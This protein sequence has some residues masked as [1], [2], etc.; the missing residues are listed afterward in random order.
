MLRNRWPNLCLPNC[1]MTHAYGILHWLSNNT[2]NNTL[3]IL[4]VK[5]KRIIGANSEN[6]S[7]IV[8]KKRRIH[9]D[10]GLG[11]TVPITALEQEPDGCTSGDG[12]PCEEGCDETEEEEE[13]AVGLSEE[14]IRRAAAL[15]ILER[16]PTAA[17]SNGWDCNWCQLPLPP[18]TIGNQT[19]GWMYLE[20]GWIER[21]GCPV[22]CEPSFGRKSIYK[23]LQW[24][25]KPLQTAPI[26]Q[27]ESLLC[28]TF[29]D[30]CTLS[31]GF[32]VSSLLYIYVYIHRSL[33]RLFW[34][35]RCSLGQILVYLY[36]SI[37]MHPV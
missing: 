6:K 8:G 20:W 13:A 28:G 12:D 16:P 9:Q 21:R 33:L 4:L 24:L 5:T 34:D 17:V 35:W 2:L 3:C 18:C 7:N 19:A 30:R 37:I 31:F 14:A 26:C 11:L 22:H 36:C 32:S 27:K 15:L 23:H 1:R 25:G 29:P 10:L